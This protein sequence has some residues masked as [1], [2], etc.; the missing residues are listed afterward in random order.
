MEAT[1][2]RYRL[3]LLVRLIDTTTG[4]AVSERNVQFL[5]NGITVSPMPRGSGHYVFLNIGREDFRLE[6]AVYGYEPA[7]VNVC[8]KKLDEVLPVTEVFLIPSENTARGARILTFSGILSNLEAIEAVRLGMSYCS[9]KGFDAKKRIMTLFRAN[10][11]DME[12]SHY[13]LIHADKK[14]YE[15]FEVEKV[16][17]STQLKLREPLQEEFRE[18]APIARSIFGKVTADGGYLLRV[19]DDAEHLKYLVRYVVAGVSKFQVVDFHDLGQAGL[20]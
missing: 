17:S 12:E 2:I 14:S 8:Y 3:D 11:P 4:M 10:G 19:R 13:G 9:I 6:A 20:E 7:A 5:R 15:P 18:N 16:L 1:N